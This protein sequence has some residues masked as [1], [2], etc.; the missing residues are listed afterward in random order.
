MFARLI[1][2]MTAITA[3][4]PKARIA[5]QRLPSTSRRSVAVISAGDAAAVG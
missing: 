4:T 1:A 5:T 3:A 2:C